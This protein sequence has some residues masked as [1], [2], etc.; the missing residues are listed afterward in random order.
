MG[1]SV[2]AQVTQM[3]CSVVIL[4]WLPP[5]QIG[6][7][8]TLQVIEAYALWIRLGVLNAMNREYPFLL[9]RGRGDE[10][11]AHLQAAGAFMGGCAVTVTAGFGAAVWVY[12]ERGPDWQWALAAYSLHAGG[13]IWRGF[14]EGTYRGGQNFRKLAL[15]HVIGVVLQIGSLPLVAGFGFR[16]FCGR[17]LGLAVAMTA[18]GHA[19]R[20]VRAAWRWNR[21]ILA[22]LVLDGLPLF[23]A[24]YLGQIS[25]QLPRVFLL[26]AGG[27]A[28]LGLYAPAAAVLA[29][30]ALLPSALLTY[31]LPARNHAYGRDGDP[32]GLATGAWRQAIWMTTLLVPL[33]ALGAWVL[34]T[35]VRDWFPEYSAGAHVLGW[36]AAASAFS[37]IRLVTSV[38]STLKAWRPMLFH[39][40]LGLLLAWL[41]PWIWLQFT[42]EDPLLAVVQGSLA[43]AVA[44][45]L[46]AWPCVRWAVGHVAK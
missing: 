30:G 27:T 25:A 39:A 24:N 10:A 12:A 19:L 15:V 11:L 41:G 9:G 38:C 4:R 34:P 5:A 44:H 23:A 42:D 20:P 3:A 46:A 35:V 8:L 37:P 7:W 18:L 28:F 17:A 36:A 14:L 2:A 22:G 26:A 43:A 6:I 31:L 1:A 33:A 32:L 45:A 13:G 21:P 40:V 16:G 29:L